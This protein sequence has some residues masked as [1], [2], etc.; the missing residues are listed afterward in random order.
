MTIKI[1]GAKENNLK[2][3]D[4]EIKEGLTV[5]TGISGSGKS[6][7]VYDTLY[8]E[9]RRR[10]IDTFTPRSFGRLPK[11]DVDSITN[12]NPAI[13]VDQNV[14]NRNPLST[15]ATASGLHPFLRILY[16]THGERYCPQ[17][18]ENLIVYSE[19]AIIDLIKNKLKENIIEI[20]TP[21]T[22]FSI[23]SH[24]TLLNMIA[25]RFAAESIIVNGKKW[26]GEKLK[27]NE[28]HSIEIKAGE[29]TKN[30]KSQQI[31]NVIQDVFELGGNLIVLK[32]KNKREIL[33]TRPICTNC[34]YWFGDLETKYFHMKCEYCDG[35]GCN[36]C[37]STG[38][39]PEASA[40]R[41][42]GLNL[43]E[44]LTLSVDEAYLKFK[45]AFFPRTTKRLEEEINKR[46]NALRKV[47][48]GYLQLNRTSPSLSRGESQ[49]VRLGIILTSRLEDML[50]ILDEP[51]IG[52]HPHD[53]VK[54]LPAFRDLAGP[55][56][57]VEHDRVAAAV[58]DNAIDIGP[59]AG[60]DGGKI[61]FS[62]STSDLWKEESATGRFFSFRE[63][64][65]IP[66]LREKPENF[67]VIN[68]AFLHN[69]KNIDV[70][71]PLER[72]TVVTGVSGSGKSTLVKH[73][74]YES[75]RREETVGCKEIDDLKIKPILVD[76]SPIGR[77]PRSNPA[78]YTK[79]S[80]II[81]DLFAEA[82]EF[83][84]SHFSFNR[85]EGRC[86]KCEGIG[87]EEVKLPYIAPIWLPCEQCHGKRFK[88]EVLEVKVDFNGRSL[89][90]GDVYELSIEEA[91]P[92]L[93]ES[94]YLSDSNRNKA[95]T[96][97]HA[98]IDIGL[99]YLHLGQAS[100]TLSGG[101]AQRV[102]LAKYL[103]RKDLSKNLIL[104]DEP[105]TGLHPSDISG[106]LIVLDRLAR[107]GATIVI[108]E[109]N[110]DIIRAA[111]WIIDLGPGAGPKGGELIFSG[112][113]EELVKNKK[114]LTAE[115][116]REEQHII[117]EKLKQPVKSYKSDT[118][119]IKGARANN[120]K[121]VSLDIPK[122]QLTV[123]T[124]LSGSGKSS[125]VTDVLEREARRRFLESLSI[126]ERQSTKEGPEAP[127]DSV[128]GLGVT[129]NTRVGG[130]YYSWRIDPRYNVGNASGII[131]YLLNLVSFLGEKQCNICGEQMI[132]E[133]CR[134]YC[135]KCNEEFI[136]TPA[137]L[138]PLSLQSHCTKCKGIGSYGLPNVDKLIIHPEK[139][140]CGGAMYSPGF[141]PFGYY[142]KQYNHPYYILRAMAEKYGYDPERTPWNE[143]SKEAQNA[144]LFGTEEIFEFEYETRSVSR[145]KR[146]SRWWG[147][148]NEWGASYFQFGDLYETY[149]D[150]HICDQ[151]DGQKLR[152]EYLTIT[153]KGKNI[154]ELKQL[155]FRELLDVLSKL[156][157]EEFQNQ[158]HLLQYWERI[159]LRLKYLIKVGLGYLNADRL[160]YTLS[161]GESERLRLVTALGSDLTSLTVLLDEPSRGLH[162]SE[163]KEMVD[164]L[165]EIRNNG[166]SVIVV[167]H[168]PEI[169]QAADYIV[170]MGPG[171]GIK[172]GKIVAQGKIEEILLTDTLTA[173]WLKGDKKT[174]PFYEK[175][176]QKELIPGRR[177]P[178]D[179]IIIN[180]ASEN[181]L[182]GE[183]FEIPLGVLSG[184]CG[185]SGSGKS[186]LVFDTLG[187]AITPEKHTTSLGS[188]KRDPGKHE[189]IKNAPE[190]ALLIDQT[191]RKVYSP[192]RFFG[193]INPLT[194]LYSESE[195]AEALEMTADDFKKGCT[196]CHGRGTFRIEMGFL[197]S[198]IST[199][200]IC[201]GTGYSPETWKIKL[202]GYSLPELSSLSIEEVYEL[203]KEDDATIA[204]YLKTAIDVGLGYLG[205][206]QPTYTMSGGEAQRLKIAKEL[207]KKAKKG[208]LY[209]LDEPTVGLHL[210]DVEG[211]IKVLQRLVDNGNT[212]LVVEHHPHV[213]AA[214]DYLIE[215]GPVGG[216]EGGYLIAKGSPE[217]LSEQ[218]TPTSQYIKKT[219]EG[220]L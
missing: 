131:K 74:L 34:D 135:K 106:L 113:V 196:E 187:I 216:P 204:R 107:A 193:L 119:S 79:L 15:L 146:K 132:R 75:L 58:A 116:L 18:Q 60:K 45:Q 179:W 87:A 13:A 48:L 162:P 152:E 67:F 134:L 185:V 70:K 40:V 93:L 171:P 3:V 136:I 101:E 145:T 32:D 11:A 112:S 114:S 129:A 177:K 161:A 50:Y 157:K 184:V 156:S 46:L 169:I 30:A 192:L 151:C 39:Y 214:C 217:E 52:Q 165:Q 148:F 6:S 72:I 47:G 120:L 102:K 83:T 104:L 80:D 56:V 100:P 76:Q 16:A 208:A 190:Q 194:K 118:I 198:V 25:E 205:L 173:K 200:D 66:D 41:W 181:N 180:G 88:E 57:F 149:T 105:S 61:I 220:K 154:H 123:V 215:L 97:L 59:G 55:V 188:R 89:S 160:N 209:I 5:V 141:W 44:L 155:T 197:P 94:I 189:S 28:K 42:E 4:V 213:L 133:E 91:T 139:P 43:P 64:V 110:T 17:C 21:I 127:V 117:P 98:L 38:L 51:T 85:P 19:D 1:T 138:S 159:K 10:Y 174:K 29:L 24:A 81:R 49:R 54:F 122:G 191:R 125:L 103:G 206:N 219:L 53:V 82:S 9:A 12:L 99:G 7:L 153:I 178:N 203:F 167:E 195:K 109:H 166:N 186:S 36:E 170:D 140:L 8:H 207:C 218:N 86:E 147:P 211:L 128:T 71:I 115:A 2:S 199:C 201:K 96:I 65:L 111:D 210:E 176:G 182:K 77:N 23:G 63:L 68:N 26:N 158:N 150:R 183:N 37:N 22:R 27:P 142:C 126:Y 172:G 84:I 73:I 62:G 175:E 121:N 90:I 168:D 212:V 202:H 14:L 164:V 108:V 130:T 78:T 31:R 69:L 143:M 163:I 95:K 137:H 35:K 92:L 144:F 20:Y 124:G 33:T